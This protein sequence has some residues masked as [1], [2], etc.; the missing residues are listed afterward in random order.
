MEVG[1]KFDPNQTSFDKLSTFYRA[2]DKVAD[3]FKRTHFAR[4]ICRKKSRA[5]SIPF[6][7]AFRH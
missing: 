5:K 4:Q 1:Q 7:R 3:Q 2:F 6:K